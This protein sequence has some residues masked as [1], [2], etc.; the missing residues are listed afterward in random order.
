MPAN[1]P[2]LSDQTT[3]LSNVSLSGTLQASRFSSTASYLGNEVWASGVSSSRV[4]SPFVSLVGSTSTLNLNAG[5][6]LSARTLAG[7]AVT[8]S[9]GGGSVAADE[10]VFTVTLGSGASLLLRSGGTIWIF[11]SAA[12][13]I[14][15]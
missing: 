8:A 2:Y 10:A 11:N 3:S 12:S 6:L 13:S 14:V 15:A 5:R 4:T 1:T 7:S 9:A